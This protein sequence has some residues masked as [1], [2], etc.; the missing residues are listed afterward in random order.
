M[1]SAI[2]DFEGE[3]WLVEKAVF[4]NDDVI[5]QPYVLSMSETNFDPW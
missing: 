5:L 3:H 4:A 2:K 1:I